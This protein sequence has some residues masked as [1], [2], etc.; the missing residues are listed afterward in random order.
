[1]AL[2]T[3]GKIVVGGAFTTIYDDNG[4]VLHTRQRIARLNAEGSVDTSFDP[5]A[6]NYVYALAV[7][8]D[9]KVVVGGVFSMLGGG[10]TTPRSRIGRLT[11]GGAAAQRLRVTAGGSI[12]SWM[13]SGAAPEVWR[14]TFE[15]SNDGVTYTSLGAAARV[16]GGW[17]LS[18]Q[19]L[20][21]NQD[22]YLRARGYYTTGLRNGSASIVESIVRTVVKTSVPFTDNVL[23]AGATMI[24]AVH[25]TELRARIDALR[26]HFGL[27]AYAYPAAPLTPFTT[28]VQATQINDLRA[29]LSQAYVAAGQPAPTFTDPVLAAQST[30]TRAVHVTEL[31]DAVLAIEP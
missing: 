27:A 2:H 7:Q 14:V 10:A 16:T 23:I 5:G 12:I 17:Q 26:I 31:R 29:A 21:T 4:G 15:S 11:N 3:D 30:V 24:R 28:I 13:R 25:I 1:M 22:V 19:S 9:G 8:E 20:P 6:N 18:G